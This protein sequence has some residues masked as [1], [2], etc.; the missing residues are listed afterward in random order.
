MAVHASEQGQLY[1]L[2][3]LL[4]RRLWQVLLPAGVVLALG[5]MVAALWPR[6][7]MVRSMLELREGSV[8][9]TSGQ[10]TDV[11]TIQRDVAAADKQ[12]RAYERVR[13]VVEKLE[14]EEYQGKSEQEKREFLVRTIRSLQVQPYKAPENQGSS[15]IE[16]RY[17]DVDPF[18][19]AEFLNQLR[20]AFVQEKVE[21]VRRAAQAS[22]LT[23]QEQ[24][25]KV[26]ERYR[27]AEGKS[28][29]HKRKFGL[30]PTQQAPGGGRQRDEDPVYELLA[31]AEDTVTRLEIDQSRLTAELETIDEQYSEAPRTL[32]KETTL[33]GVDVSDKIAEIETEIADYRSKLERIRPAHRDYKRWMREIEKLEERIVALQRTGRPESTIQ[34]TMENPD[35][36]ALFSKKQSLT[37]QLQSIEAGLAKAKTQRESFKKKVDEQAEIYREDKV[38]EGEAMLTQTLFR[39]AKLDFERQER[40]VTLI[41]QPEFNPFEVIE[42]ALPPTK[43]YAPNLMLVLAF[44][45]AVALAF[46][47]GSA[48]FAEYYRGAYRSVSDVTRGTDLP[49]LGAINRIETRA[50]ARW[51]MLQRFLVGAATA[52]VIGSILWI[53]WAYTSRRQLL[54]PDLARFIDDVR[55][56]L[57]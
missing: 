36:P 21:S 2:L 10:S 45:A 57:Y 16:A 22:L 6:R 18:R 8:P 41:N 9:L 47:V 35:R 42:F 53:T 15:F 32:P 43:P 39:D 56:E 38:L 40:Y 7:Y 25:A 37:A 12:M 33:E 11:R 24:L 55:K 31:K 13:R 29:A 4:K 48:L 3:E 49:V 26:E 52:L 51:R 54:G 34:E 46:G 20:E 5:I 28:F 17:S 30:S 23:L 44:T 50:Q 14:W 27:V 1:E 19:A